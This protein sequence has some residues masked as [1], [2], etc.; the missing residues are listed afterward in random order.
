MADAAG[1]FHWGS[2]A[3]L[4]QAGCGSF[5]RC[6]LTFSL[7][8]AA[9]APSTLQDL[10]TSVASMPDDDEVKRFVL[11]C[12]LFGTRRDA[13]VCT[14]S[15]LS[16]DVYARAGAFAVRSCRGCWAPLRRQRLRHRPAVM[17]QCQNG[18]L[19]PSDRF[20]FDCACSRADHCHMRFVSY[21][22]AVLIQ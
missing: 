2:L 5:L 4:S 1:Y 11:H 9:A 14:G 22:L 20:M 21:N 3:P 6:P 8:D 19:E 18:S 13:L 10:D 16:V 15:H 7:D 12:M 17:P